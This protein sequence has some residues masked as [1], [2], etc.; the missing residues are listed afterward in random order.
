MAAAVAAVMM[1]SI[2]VHTP[3]VLAAAAQVAEEAQATPQLPGLMTSVAV[4]AVA[5]GLKAVVTAALAW[6]SCACRTTSLSRK[7]QAT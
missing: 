1:L 3:A 6:L 2:P 5:A 7:P 4:A